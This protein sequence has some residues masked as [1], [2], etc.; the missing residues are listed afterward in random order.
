MS[1]NIIQITEENLRKAVKSGDLKQLAPELFEKK[2]RKVVIKNIMWEKDSE[3]IVYPYE[4]SD[5]YCIDDYDWDDLL[6]KPPM[7]MTLEW[8]E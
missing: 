4:E 5:D 2:K 6:N 7:L 1:N 8:E 3:E